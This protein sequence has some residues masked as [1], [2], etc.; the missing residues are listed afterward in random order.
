MAKSRRAPSL[1]VYADGQVTNWQVLAVGRYRGHRPVDF[2]TIDTQQLTHSSAAKFA[3]GEIGE[4][5]NN[6]T[7]SIEIDGPGGPPEQIHFGRVS[8]MDIH[9]SERGESRILH[10]R[11]DDHLFG[12]PLDQV[13][14]LVRPLDIAED[15]PIS[16]WEA[17]TEDG[18]TIF[19]PTMDGVP[20]PNRTAAPPGLGLFIDP[21]SLDPENLEDD[22]KAEPELQTAVSW[23]TLADAANYL[24]QTLNPTG[25]PIQNP[26]L[27]ELQAVLGTDPYQLRNHRALIGS[28][29]PEELDRLLRPHG[30][31]FRVNLISRATRKIEVYKSGSGTPFSLKLQPFG[32]EVDNEETNLANLR[33]NYD[34]VNNSFNE[35]SHSGNFTEH[36]ISVLLR[37]GWDTTYDQ[38]PDVSKFRKGSDDFEGSLS[39]QQAWRRFVANEGGGYD[40]PWWDGA[41]DFSPL[42]LPFN[43]RVRRHQMRPTITLDTA[44]ASIGRT[45]G[46]FLEWWDPDEGS[47][48]WKPIQAI[49]DEGMSWQPLEDELGVWFSG[50]DA[51]RVWRR[52]AAHHGLDALALRATFTLRSDTKIR[53]TITESGAGGILSTPRREIVDSRGYAIREISAINPATLDGD[54]VGGSAVALTGTI[55]SEVDDSVRIVSKTQDLIDQY[56]RATL[57]G[58]A[59][60]HGIDWNL[61]NAVG[62][63][64]ADIVGRNF[65]FNVAPLAKMPKFPTIVGVEFDIQ[66]Q[67]TRLRLETLRNV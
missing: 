56:N 30:F 61:G 27:G 58:E 44:G 19:N 11:L 43:F 65:E 22:R 53:S 25:A 8:A 34:A 20:T 21:L 15:A 10:S 36:E 62:L 18:D 64:I 1:F 12:S 26:S 24:I 28:Y 63:T 54:P 47:G 60:L 46:I 3:E 13:R 9:I 52:I 7:I 45:F 42:F 66:Q 32:D 29:L 55:T 33:V 31:N 23:W 41:I 49:D 17:S 39:V 40:R 37:P 16:E 6:S 50:I 14:M 67:K 51:P 38:D 59:D 48:E 5:F 35:I 2:A 57:E 4:L